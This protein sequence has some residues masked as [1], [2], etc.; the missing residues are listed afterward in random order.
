[1]PR[2]MGRH[3]KRRRFIS[4]LH[5]LPILLLVILLLIPF[6]EPHILTVDSRVIE[7]TSIPAGMRPLRVVFVSDLHVRS[8][9]FYTMNQLSDLVKK[10]NSQNPDL[11]LLGGDY[12]ENPEDTE[13]F[14]R[15]LP[16][17]HSNYGIYAVLG[18]HDRPESQQ[19]LSRL[20]AAMVAKNVT[21]LINDV[22]TVRV[23]TDTEVQIAGL[24]DT[25]LSESVLSN[26]VQ[27]C[28][29]ENYVILMCHNPKIIK[30]LQTRT[31]TGGARNWYDLAFFGHT[32]GGQIGF[33]RNLLN[34]TDDVPDEYMQGTINE[35]RMIHIVSN[36][37]GTSVL[38]IRMMCPPQIHLCIIRYPQ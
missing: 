24:D 37:I 8:W 4:I 15:S 29:P 23:G 10:I 27:V 30:Q 6:I 18:E 19:D 12:A 13:A 11:V 25:S 31:G 36:G 33:A 32:H 2:R 3:A 35:G 20:R 17:I 16:T 22:V 5:A 21:P 34:I 1:M 9:P 28:K 7:S 38:P 14:F 26:L